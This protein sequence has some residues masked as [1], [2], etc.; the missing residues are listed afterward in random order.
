MKKKPKDIITSRWLRS[1][2]FLAILYFSQIYPFSPLH[3]DHGDSLLEFGINSFPIEVD[4]EHSSDHHHHDT[5]EPHTNDHQHSFDN[6]IDWHIVRT[7]NPRTS[8]FDELYFFSSNPY[9]FANNNS[10]FNSPLKE[11]LYIEKCQTSAL[12]IRG[13]P[14]LG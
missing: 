8:T 1:F 5:D 6:H 2:L 9:V 14:L 4:L 7:Q 10:L 11:Y 12:V 13:P 3:H